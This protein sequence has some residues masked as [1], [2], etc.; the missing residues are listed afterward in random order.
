MSWYSTF[1]IG[2]V[3]IYTYTFFTFKCLHTWAQTSLI[4]FEIIVEIPK[5]LLDT[6]VHFY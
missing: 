6:T 5:Y 4:K 2:H 1:K 3:T